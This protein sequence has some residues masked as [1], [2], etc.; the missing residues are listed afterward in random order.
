MQKCVGIS[1]ILLSELETG[2]STHTE[3][4][5]VCIQYIFA[6]HT[7]HNVIHTP[8]HGK[9]KAVARETMHHRLEAYSDTLN[10]ESQG[11]NS[12]RILLLPR[13]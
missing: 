10:A 5:Y 7:I 4:I 8:L 2:I 13:L 1:I 12:A 11:E 6:I 3:T 9:S